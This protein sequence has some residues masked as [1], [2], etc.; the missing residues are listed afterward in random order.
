MGGGV[1]SMSMFDMMSVVDPE[2]IAE[3]VFEDP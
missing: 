2:K 3:A 1:E